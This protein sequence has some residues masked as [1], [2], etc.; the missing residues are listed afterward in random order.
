MSNVQTSP[1]EWSKLSK[2]KNSSSSHPQKRTLGT[3]GWKIQETG[4]SPDNSGGAIVFLPTSAIEKEPNLNK[5]ALLITG[6]QLEMLKRL[7]RRL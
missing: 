4:A 5:T 6:L 3:D 2:I 7:L 1:T